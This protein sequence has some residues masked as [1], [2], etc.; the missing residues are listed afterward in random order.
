MR[1]DYPEYK[2]ARDEFLKHKLYCAIK[3]PVC[4]RRV[5]CVHHMKG[6]IGSNLTNAEFF[7][8]SCGACN[9]YVEQHPKWALENGKRLLRLT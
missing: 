2:R 5:D 9:G 8:E 1:K 6:R 4:T 3:S 7:M